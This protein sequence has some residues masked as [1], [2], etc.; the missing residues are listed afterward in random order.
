MI[1]YRTRDGDLLDDICKRCYGRESAVTDVLEANPGLAVAKALQDRLN[2]GAAT[3]S[4]TL[5]GRPELAAG[6]PARLSGFGR[7]VDGDWGPPGWSTPWGRRAIN[8]DWHWKRGK[9]DLRTRRRMRNCPQPPTNTDLRITCAM[10]QIRLR[11]TPA[12]YNPPF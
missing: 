9:R 11:V 1:Q 3:A 4:L 12:R 6:T 10:S 5:P 2:R 7:G 8:R